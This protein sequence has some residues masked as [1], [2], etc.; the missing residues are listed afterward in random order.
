MG[1]EIGNEVRCIV[2][3]KIYTVTR[4]DNVGSIAINGSHVYYLPSRYTLHQSKDT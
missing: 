3:G 2:P 4:I 1:F